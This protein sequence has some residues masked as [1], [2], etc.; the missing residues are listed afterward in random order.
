MA[1]G[2]GTYHQ[3]SPSVGNE[4][5]LPFMGFPEIDGALIYSLLEHSRM[6]GPKEIFIDTD[7]YNEIDDQFTLAPTLLAENL[8]SEIQFVAIGVAP[9]HNQSRNTKDFGNFGLWMKRTSLK[10]FH[11]HH[12]AKW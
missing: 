7:S 8:V 11:P 1:N 5:V 3:I 12:A 6:K 4:K 10:R 2:K 9:F